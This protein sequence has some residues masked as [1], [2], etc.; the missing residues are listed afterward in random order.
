MQQTTLA[1]TVKPGASATHV[2]LADGVVSVRVKEPAREG[3]A[4]E[5]CRK[6]LANALGVAPSTVKLL[7][8]TKS[9]L[10]VFIL[11][12]LTLVDLRQRLDRLRSRR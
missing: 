2:S 3:K 1:V 10:K 8:G 12:T 7:R 6:A 4:N 5:A 9:R 11:L